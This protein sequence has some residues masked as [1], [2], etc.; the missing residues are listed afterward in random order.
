[1]FWQISSFP[2][3]KHHV[4]LSHCA[5]DRP[6]LVHR[7]YDELM[8]RRI[9]PW[10]DKEEYYYGRDSR[11]ALRDGLLRSRHVVFFVTLG[12][13]D[14]RRG[15]CLMELAYSELLQANLIHAG[16]PLVNFELPLFFLDRNDAALSRTAWNTLRNRGIFHHPS[17]GDPVTWAV[18]QIVAFLHREQDLALDMA[19]AIVPGQPV[20]KTLA[21]RYGL[22]ERVTQFDPSPVPWRARSAPSREFTNRMVPSGLRQQRFPIIG[23]QDALGERFEIGRLGDGCDRSVGVGIRTEPSRG[24]P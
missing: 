5:I 9:V 20:Y 14:Y 13:M 1:M 10:L 22:V 7:V 17:D 4:F 15:W 3:C 6:K 2:R 19:K 8:R 16:G 18:D 21:S 12:M 11:T 23:S 24:L